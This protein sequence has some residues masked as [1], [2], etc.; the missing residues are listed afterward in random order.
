MGTFTFTE[1][2]LGSSPI[3]NLHHFNLGLAGPQTVE[4]SFP[5]SCF[6]SVYH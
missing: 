6:K 5:L 4:N 3:V 2:W 1:G